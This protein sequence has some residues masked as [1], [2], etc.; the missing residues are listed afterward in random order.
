MVVTPEKHLPLMQFLAVSTNAV[1]VRAEARC[2]VLAR[3][4]S[5]SA[6][7]FAVAQGKDRAGWQKK[8]TAI[9][10]DFGV[11]LRKA[12]MFDIGGLVAHAILEHSD[13]GTLLPVEALANDELEDVD[14]DDHGSDPGCLLGPKLRLGLGSQPAPTV[15]KPAAWHAG[16]LGAAATTATTATSAAA[17][18]TQRVFRAD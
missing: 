16:T 14:T 1:K 11:D 2:T 12:P 13:V 7:W 3:A 4:M 6:W 17:S 18:C 5:F 8:L 15:F 10:G 9:G